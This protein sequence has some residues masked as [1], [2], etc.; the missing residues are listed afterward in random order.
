MTVFVTMVSLT[1]LLVLAAIMAGLIKLWPLFEVGLVTSMRYAFAHADL[2]IQARQVELE[3]ARAKALQESVIKLDEGQT[4]I[5]ERPNLKEIGTKPTQPIPDDDINNETSGMI[6]SLDFC[7]TIAKALKQP[8]SGQIHIIA[9][10]GIGK[11]TLANRL[12]ADI[13]AQLPNAEIILIDPKYKVAEPDWSIH[14]ICTDIEGVP[15]ALNQQLKEMVARKNDPNFSEATTRF[16]II[17][18]DDVDYCYEE[19]GEK[20]ASPLRKLAKMC[21][22]LNM[23]LIVLGQTNQTKDCGLS[24]G[25]QRQFSQIL[26]GRE[27]IAY[28]NNSRCQLPKAEKALFKQVAQLALQKG[29]RFA[30]IIPLQ[31]KEFLR[32]I[33]HLPKPKTPVSSVSDS[34]VNVFNPQTTS[35]PKP[36]QDNPLQRYVGK[37][38]GR[39]LEMARC[40]LKG[41][42]KT[43]SRNHVTGDNT[44]LGE[45][46]DRIKTELNGAVTA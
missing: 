46:Y 35:D 6:E 20:V 38:N 21:R 33:P 36:P 7:A 27:V 1:C 24:G 11:S 12:L 42:S 13:R 10:T 40:I 26:M 2:D 25:S 15:S 45:L 31:T 22:G 29:H 18:L 28:L 14:P 43:K 8:D 34:S 44:Y 16:K 30:L 32:K 5:S 9:P 23:R 4:A 41:W 37:D 17:I 19:H 39:E 3:Q